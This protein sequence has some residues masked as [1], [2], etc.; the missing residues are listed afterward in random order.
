ML[1]EVVPAL[2]EI[3]PVG[4]NGVTDPVAIAVPVLA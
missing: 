2:K 1:A 4:R 3:V